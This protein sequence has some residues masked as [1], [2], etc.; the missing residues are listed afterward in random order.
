[1][2]SIYA[3]AAFFIVQIEIQVQNVYSLMAADKH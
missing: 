2:F 3:E 1:M